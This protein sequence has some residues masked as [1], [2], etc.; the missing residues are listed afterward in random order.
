MPLSR[1]SPNNAQY[2]GQALMIT[3]QLMLSRFPL[4]IS[5]R[6]LHGSTPGFSP[7]Y[8]LQVE[9]EMA[10]AIERNIEQSITLMTCRQR[11]RGSANVSYPQ[12]CP[13]F[14]FLDALRYGIAVLSCRLSPERC[15]TLSLERGS[16]PLT[17]LFI[18]TQSS[19]TVMYCGDSA[20]MG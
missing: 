8:R 17:Q 4:C 7:L 16:D 18:G 1:V 12:F 20:G 13:I 9:P 2:R 3:P 5:R 6:G 15:E 19:S 11:G 14:G 10:A